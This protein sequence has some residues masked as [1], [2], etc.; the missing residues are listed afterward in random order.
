MCSINGVILFDG[1]RSFA[2]LKAIDRF[3]KRTIVRA[4]ERGKDACGV[5]VLKR[6]P[7][8]TVMEHRAVAEAR[9]LIPT[10]PM[11]VHEK[12]VIV[13]N[14]N[15]NAPSTEGF[16][17][18][19]EDVQPF[20]DGRIWVAHNGI[21]A[22]DRILKKELGIKTKSAVDSS[23]IPFVL[24]QHGELE[25]HA[26]KSVFSETFVGSFS[27][28]LFDAQK[29]ELWLLRD[30]RPLVLAYHS[31]WNC[32]FFSSEAKYLEDTTVPAYLSSPL[33][34][35]EPQPYSIIKVTTDGSIERRDLQ[36]RGN[37]NALIVCS[38][39]LDSTTVAAYAKYV[40]GCDITLVHFLYGC[41]AEEAEKK[42]IVDIAAELEC[43]YR[44]EDLSWL[45]ELGGSNLTDQS[46][47][48]AKGD[49]SA[50]TADSWVPA[51][52]TVMMSLAGALCDR[53]GFGII[54]LGNNLEESGGYPDNTKEF[55]RKLGEVFDLGTLARPIVSDPLGNLT[56]HGIV[57]M[58]FKTGAPVHKSYSCYHEGPIHCGECGPCHMR[59][60]A[61]KMNHYIDPMEYQ[62]PQPKK[63]WKGC[64]KVHYEDGRWLDEDG[65]GWQ[66]S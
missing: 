29:E 17:M 44:F 63:F 54:Y 39:G 52:N 10:L 45:G 43:D 2:E 8:P 24:S 58:A 65:C 15:R 37:K 33:K 20:S 51:R 13:V 27:C 7:K 30:Y 66:V 32:L 9:N 26:I 61:F 11:I 64:K 18:S 53:F 48:V 34:I 49:W 50:E 16:S 23:I 42:A 19:P 59:I 31:K 36:P 3:L 56:K 40:D 28:A 14:N 6:G 60:N 41:R 62:K 47:E 55:F 57:D 25:W 5:A 1:D 35:W 38:G 4:Q 21:L 22:N 46:L 12:T